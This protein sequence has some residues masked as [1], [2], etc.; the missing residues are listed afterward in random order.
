MQS[1]DFE[2]NYY[3]ARLTASRDRVGLSVPLVEQICA[4]LETTLGADD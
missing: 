1:F 4:H 3:E 2:T